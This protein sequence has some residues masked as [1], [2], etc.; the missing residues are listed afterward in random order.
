M[1]FKGNRKCN[2]RSILSPKREALLGLLSDQEQ[3]LRLFSSE[4]DVPSVFVL[5]ILS[6]GNIDGKI[7]TDHYESEDSDKFISFSTTDIF[8]SLKNL[9]LFDTCLKIVNFGP[10]RG[11]YFD[12][13][14]SAN[15]GKFDNENS[16]RI[17]YEPKM[18]NLVVFYSTV[19]TTR[20]VRGESG[21]IFA[22]E[23]CNVI[24]SMP[25]DEPL[26]NVFTSIQFQIY[27]NSK[28]NYDLDECKYISQTPEIKIF[29]MKSNFSFSK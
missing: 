9:T 17:T 11:E 21:T 3:L 5:Y 2:F 7:C 14:Y 23:S 10:C 18:R 1:T 16:C 28:G 24:N 8:D 19:E 29:A 20:A 27:Q 4:D 26:V 6:F 12:T 22:Q 25:K 13:I 15:Q